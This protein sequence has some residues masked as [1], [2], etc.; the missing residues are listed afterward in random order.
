MRRAPARA[1]LGPV[2]EG[3][4]AGVRLRLSPERV[5]W[6]RWRALALIA[7]VILGFAGLLSGVGVSE[8]P[9][10]PSAGVLPKLYYTFGLFLLGGMDLGT[11]NGGPWLGRAVLWAAYFAAPAITASAVIET[12]LAVLGM[13]SLWLRRLRGHVV[14]VGAGRMTELY[15]RRL[16]IHR[17]R[18]PVVVIGEAH[19]ASA[20]EDLRLTFRAQVVVGDITSIAM[21][22]RLRLARA[23]RVLLLGE[24]DFTNLDAASRILAVAPELDRRLIVHVGDLRFL[25]SMATSKL[26]GRCTVFNGHQIAAAHLVDAHLLAHFRRTEP[27]DVVVLAGFGRFGQ[28]VL[29][30]LQRRAAGAFERVI[31]VDLDGRRARAEFDDEVGVLPGY[32]LDVVEGDLRDPGVWREV[33]ARLGSELE[34][35]VFV[36]GSGVDRIDLRIALGIARR[37]ADAYVVARSEKQWT[38]AE[39]VSAEAGIHTVSVARLVTESMPSSWFGDRTTAVE[40]LGPRLE[41]APEAGRSDTR[42]SAAAE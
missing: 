32:V 15:L 13:D 33:E 16:R 11:P 41:A 2:V 25:R 6:F 12:V 38:F 39:E 36:V 18:V 27:Q 31:I 3:L 20:L 14:V 37:H 23:A 21:L 19:D 28:T 24:D 30:E 17:P 9:D 7:V 10:L 42:S 4:R 5:R 26:A 22:E 29:D 8:R 40:K 35:P 34:A 1:I